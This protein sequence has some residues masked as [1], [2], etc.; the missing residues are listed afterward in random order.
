MAR[1]W[2]PFPRSKQVKGTSLRKVHQPTSMV[3]LAHPDNANRPLNERQWYSR[4]K[5]EWVRV[6][7]TI[8]TPRDW[9]AQFG[10]QPHEGRVWEA[11][12]YLIPL[13]DEGEET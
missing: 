7:Y 8:W 4:D 10:S 5:G 11:F 3:R 1:R 9:Q 6:G 2:F 13:Y 12:G